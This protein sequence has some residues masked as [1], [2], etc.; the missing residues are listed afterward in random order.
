MQV[1]LQV[2]WSI[3]QTFLIFAF[4]AWA[5]RLRMIRANNLAGLSRLALDVFFPFLTFSTITRNFNP[6]HMQ[7]LWLMPLIGFGIMLSSALI[8][9]LFKKHLFHSTPERH[10]TLHHICAINNYVFL[11]LIVLDSLWGERHIALLLLMN[12]GSTIGFWTIGILTFTGFG[13]L[14]ETVKNIFS[15]NLAAVVIALAFC[16]LRIPIPHFIASTSE[17]MGSMAVPFMLI[18]TGAALYFS[19]GNLLKHPLDAAYLS[20]LRLLVLPAVLIF[21]LKL[22]PLEKDM[23]EVSIVVAL[24]PAAAS[25]VLIAKR[26]GGCP[27]FTGQAII[28]TTLLSLI[29]IPL[30]LWILL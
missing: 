3:L 17:M 1:A 15:I 6:T 28:V 7:E 2:F 25:S 9:F 29:T 8:G 26:Y 24:M 21:L 14:R 23:F 4:G 19:A 20:V 12:V 16:F 11:P 10:A 30:W 13:S 5:V 27:D 22:F 18:L